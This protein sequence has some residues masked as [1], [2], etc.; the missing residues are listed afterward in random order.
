VQKKEVN[1]VLFDLD[2]VLVDSEKAWFYVFNDT[3]KHFGVKSVSKKW[4]S[5]IF[6]NTIEKNVKI[7][8]NITA[9][10][11]NK[12]AIKYFAKNR[13]YVKVFPNSRNVLEKLSNNN[14]KMALITN[15]PKRILIPTLKHYKLKKY[16]KAI[17][18]VDDVKRGKPS[19]DMALKA[20]RLLKVKPKNTILIGDTKN[21][22]VAGKRAGCIT[23]GYGVKGEHRIKRLK[24]IIK[25]VK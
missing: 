25:F 16:F 9:K 17:V 5:K 15:T 1:A 7:F 24:S 2:G 11:A 10:E 12:L 19:P 6:G 21:D 13:R 8:I 23:V 20:C 3:L 18:T 22:M 4:F 14:V